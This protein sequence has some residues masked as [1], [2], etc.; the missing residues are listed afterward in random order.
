[1]GPDNADKPYV[2]LKIEAIGTP[3]V[4]LLAQVEQLAEV[5]GPLRSQPPGHGVS[6]ESG[7]L[8]LAGLDDG[9]RHDGKVGVD[10]AAADG[11]ALPLTGAALA[12]VGVTL[13]E[14]KADTALGEDALLHGE[15]LLV[16]ATGDAEHVALP[17]VTEAVGGHFHA[18]A[19]LV[20]GT[21]LVFIVDLKEFLAPG[22]RVGNVDLHPGLTPNR[23]TSMP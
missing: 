12:V 3:D 17:L 11:L 13:L 20:E 10:D 9:H 22:G 21:N 19:L 14:E 6:G 8:G 18:H 1:M 2:W 15:T 23:V 4:V 7:D 5:R 16:V